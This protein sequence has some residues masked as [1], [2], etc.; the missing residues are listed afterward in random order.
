MKN[1][2]ALISAEITWW[3]I[4][5]LVLAFVLIAITML[6]KQGIGII[7]YIKTFLRFGR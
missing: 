5:L 2:K 7:D 3:I 4:A 1:K 6:Q